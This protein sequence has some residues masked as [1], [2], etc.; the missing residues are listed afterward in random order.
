MSNEGKMM[1]NDTKKT[2][3]APLLKE[4][5]LLQLYQGT[6]NSPITDPDTDPDNPFS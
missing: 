3:E 6:E 1:E 2:Y 5:Q 4:E